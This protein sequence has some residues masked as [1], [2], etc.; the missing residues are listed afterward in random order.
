[1]SRIGRQ[2]FLNLSASSIPSCFSVTHAWGCDSAGCDSAGWA[3]DQIELVTHDPPALAMRQT[4]SGH[5]P[6]S[7]CQA[8]CALDRYRHWRHRRTCTDNIFKTSVVAKNL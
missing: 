7:L 3:D 4:P 1:M 5:H 2:P 8:A 6:Q